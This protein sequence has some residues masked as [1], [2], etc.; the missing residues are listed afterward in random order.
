TSPAPAG[1]AV[2]TLQG[3]M[4]GQ[5][6]VPASV[7][8]PA[9]SLSASFTTTP[10]PET[11]FPRWVYIGADYGTTGG[12]MARVLEIDPGAGGP[13]TL[14]A[15]GPAGQDLI[16]GNPG[17]GSVALVIPAPAGGAVVNLT[18]DNPSVLHVPTSVAIGQGNSAVSFTIGTSAVSGL[19]TGGNVTASAGGVTKSIFVTVHPDPNAPPLL[20]SLSISPTSVTGGTSAT[21]TVFFSAPAPSGGMSVTL[22]TS[23]A[24]VARAPG[25]VNVPAGQTSASFNLTTFAVSAD[26]SA[27]ITA[28]LDSA[29]TA[30]INVTRGAPPAPSPTPVAPPPTPAPSATPVPAL[31]APSQLTPAAD[32]RFAP[33]TNVTFDWSDVNG[34]ASYTIQVSTQD[35]FPSSIVNQNVTA[36]Q[37]STSTLPTSTMWWRVRAN[38]A[39][40]KAGAWS[41]ARRFELKN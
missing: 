40:G 14:L 25:I 19:P 8:V 34:A 24:G 41:A 39:S 28:F 26:T 18:T 12:S 11:P 9:G 38:D 1:G 27:T 29:R 36:S 4:E 35:T 33:G 16:G 2:V 13:P 31:A 6:I 23:N 30:T 20:Q 21:G 15:I 37:F 5:V 3:S 17:R 32:A 10:A 22:S 7:T